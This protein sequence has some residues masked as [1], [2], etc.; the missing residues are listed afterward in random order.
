MSKEDTGKFKYHS[1]LFHFERT[2]FDQ[3][4]QTRWCDCLPYRIDDGK[5]DG[6][7]TGKDDGKHTGKNL[8]QS[9]EKYHNGRSDFEK[10]DNCGYGRSDFDK[11]M[12]TKWGCC[13]CKN[14]ASIAPLL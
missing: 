13:N 11:Y 6:K 10:Y 3:K 9:I 4:L 8:K 12:N 5:D 14:G 1:G 7:H 2:E